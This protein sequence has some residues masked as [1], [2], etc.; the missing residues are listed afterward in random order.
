MEQGAWTAHCTGLWVNKYGLGHG[1]KGMVGDLHEPQ[2]LIKKLGA[3]GKEHGLRIALAAMVN[4][5][6]WSREHGAGSF[7]PFAP[8]SLLFTPCPLPLALI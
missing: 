3:W 2:W 4:K 1:A 6:A 5:I 8:C 7:Q